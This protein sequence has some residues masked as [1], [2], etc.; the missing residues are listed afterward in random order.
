LD[1]KNQLAAYVLARLYL[2]IGE[3]GRAE[4]LLE[5][6]LDRGA[7][8]ADA[9]A[10]LG[11]LRTKAGDHAEAEELYQLGLEKL[12]SAEK[13]LKSL[14][15]VY[16]LSEQKRKL[17]ETLSRLAKIDWDN[18]LIR[19][20]LVELAL[21]RQDFPTAVR[22]GRQALHIDVTDAEIHAS[23]AR[24]CLEQ[25]QYEAAAR[26]FASA[27]RIDPKRSE[28]R[29]LLAQARAQAGDEHGA[30]GALLDLLKREPEHKQAKEMLQE[31]GHGS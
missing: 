29:V 15:R 21:E 3:S 9:L 2:S 30:R 5:E 23:V 18:V 16:L 31:L 8:Q 11:G 26:G 13:W 12:P 1:A 20:K 22:W 7:P 25:Q 19:K 28:W 27:V 14:A 17:G 4:I 10:L 6:S 24:A